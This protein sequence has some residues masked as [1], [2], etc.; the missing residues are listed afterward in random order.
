MG[1]LTDAIN[2]VN[3]LGRQNLSDKGVIVAENATTYE[4]MSAI[5]DV[6]GSGGVVEKESVTATLTVVPNLKCAANIEPS[7]SV[8]IIE[9]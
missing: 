1:K 9:E 3:V 2:T 7:G 4:I 8:E 6:S 5:A